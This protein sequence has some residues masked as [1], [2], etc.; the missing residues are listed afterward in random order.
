VVNEAMNAGR[1]VIAS[2]DVGCQEDLV[3]DGVNGAVFPARDVPG[4]AWAIERVLASPETAAQMGEH[5]RRMVAEYSFEQDVR[6]LR[7]ALAAC[8]PGFVA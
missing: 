7:Q 6:G 5:G 4:L 1:A 2:D 8:V 3:R